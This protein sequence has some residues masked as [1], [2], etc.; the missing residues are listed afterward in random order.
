MMGERVAIALI[1]AI[2]A[3]S[4][5]SASSRGV[6]LSAIRRKAVRCDR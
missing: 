2:S 6:K 4:A 1:A 3:I 5:I